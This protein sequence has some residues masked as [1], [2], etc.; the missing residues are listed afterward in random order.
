M[1]NQIVKKLAAASVGAFI[2]TFSLSS[3]AVHD[4]NVAKAYYLDRDC[5]VYHMKGDQLV[6]GN[7]WRNL[8][9]PAM[10]YRQDHAGRWF[11]SD[12]FGNRI[13]KSQRCGGAACVYK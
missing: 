6:V 1:K 10:K 3:F 13:Y 9:S 8:K 2:A 11:V 5:Y 7:K 4:A 12:V